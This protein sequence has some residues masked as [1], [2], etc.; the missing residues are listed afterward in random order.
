MSHDTI[1]TEL[2]KLRGEILKLRKACTALALECHA[3]K[4]AIFPT[5]NLA[6]A[7]RTVA[8]ILGECEL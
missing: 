5:S 6:T 4:R 1:S 8:D 7:K 2:V 3:T